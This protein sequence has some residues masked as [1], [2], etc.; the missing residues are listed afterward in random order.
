[1]INF[2]FDKSLQLLPKRIVVT[3]KMTITLIAIGLLVP[4]LI[5]LVLFIQKQNKVKKPRTPAEISLQYAQKLLQ[6]KDLV[7]K[8]ACL[9]SFEAY[10]PWFLEWQTS[11]KELLGQIITD[12]TDRKTN[13]LALRAVLLANTDN[14]IRTHLFL[15]QEFSNDQKKALIHI[16]QLPEQEEGQVMQSMVRLNC[17]AEMNVL[18]LKWLL[19]TGYQDGVD[20]YHSLYRQVITLY[21]LVTMRLFLQESFEDT[22][23]TTQI[24]NLV[25]E[26]RNSLK[27]GQKLEISRKK[28]SQLESKIKKNFENFQV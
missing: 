12:S 25:Q 8:H 17:F 21:T 13:Q 10:P 26:V 22:S 15:S 28:L 19:Q 6:N 9:A 3:V 18:L 14:L 20:D 24:N 4:F 2:K 5:F 1:M 16:I 23:I 27:K 7:V 11:W